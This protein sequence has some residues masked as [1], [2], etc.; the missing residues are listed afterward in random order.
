LV[1]PVEWDDDQ[2][3]NRGEGEVLGLGKT[4][5]LTLRYESMGS[6]GD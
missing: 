4:K 6:K 5:I 3:N 1:G 2:E